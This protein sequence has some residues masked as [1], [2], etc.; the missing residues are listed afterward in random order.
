MIYAVIV[1]A[2]L[3]VG[4]KQPLSYRFMSKQEIEAIHAPTP[5]PAKPG[6]WMWDSSKRSKLDR[7]AYNRRSAMS[8]SWSP[9]R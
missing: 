5:A 2:V 7:G 6:A 1:V 8:D 3:T 9:Y 4:W